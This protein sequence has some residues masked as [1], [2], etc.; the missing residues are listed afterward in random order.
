MKKKDDNPTPDFGK[1]AISKIK[2]NR[3]KG[4]PDNK[5]NTFSRLPQNKKRISEEN[6][7][8]WKEL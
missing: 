4:N 5:N 2:L 7:N 1:S 3:L 6:E 8:F